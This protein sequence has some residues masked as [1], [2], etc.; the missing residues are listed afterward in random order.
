MSKYSGAFLLTYNYEL[1]DS[2]RVFKSKRFICRSFVSQFLQAVFSQT[3]WKARLVLQD[4]SMNQQTINGNSGLTTNASTGTDTYGILVGTGTNAVT[5]GDYA[6][7]TKI[8]HGTSSGQLQYGTVSYG[9]PASDSTKTTYRTTRVFTNNS[10][11]T[12]VVTEIGLVFQATNTAPTT[13]YF[14]GMRDTTSISISNGQQLTLNY[15][16]IAYA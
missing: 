9:A 16:M 7:Q 15:N 5:I 10:G 14:L 12:V 1:K 13:T 3:H 2:S 6:L 11:S 4:T 8:A